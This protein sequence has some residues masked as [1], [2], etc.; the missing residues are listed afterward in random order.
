M[1]SVSDIEGLRFKK[2]KKIDQPIS[3]YLEHRKRRCDKLSEHNRGNCISVD[4][5]IQ[6]KH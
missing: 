3:V 5:V 1:L 4:N 6:G 2:N